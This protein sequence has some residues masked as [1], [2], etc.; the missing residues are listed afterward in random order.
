V[1]G[2]IFGN[3]GTMEYKASILIIMMLAFS[4]SYLGGLRNSIKTDYFQM[5]IF[6]L[7]LLTLLVSL[8]F[9]NLLIEFNLIA[10][11]VRDFSNPG[12][13][14]IV[15][16]L[17]QVWS[18]P[19]HDPVMMDRGFICSK[20]KTK[21]SF[22][23]AFLLSSLCIFSFSLLGLHLSPN[24]L[25]GISFIEAVKIN[26]DE[27]LAYIIF[28]LLI[29]SAISTLDSTLSSAAK[30]IVLDLSLLSKTI[31]NGRLV[32][33]IFS[34]LGLIFIFS[35]TKDLYTAVAVSGTAATFLTS[36][37][38]LRIAFNISVSN[39]SLIISFAF[40]IFGSIIYY[41]EAQNINNLFSSTFELDH[42]YKTLLFL[43]IIIIFINFL[44]ALIKKRTS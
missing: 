25:N 12:Y 32:M 1:I 13:A 2:L 28:L 36:T 27:Y 14:L 33:L 44:S 29:V 6:L 8:Y 39:V 26:F 11:K 20:E 5:I 3:E 22:F 38:I 23:L 24:A 17:L 37:F 34:I 18:Y 40:S 35:N 19:I 42:K 43:N 15:V 10:T 4:Y 7:L 16:A 9:S 21:K 30:L 41:L 31:L